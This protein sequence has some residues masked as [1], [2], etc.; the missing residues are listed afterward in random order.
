MAKKIT[1]LSV[2]K[3]GGYLPHVRMLETM[4]RLLSVVVLCLSVCLILGQPVHMLPPWVK[5]LPITKYVPEVAQFLAS[6]FGGE[7]VNIV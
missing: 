7:L 5:L 3:Y 1:F 2:Y 6:H 4:A